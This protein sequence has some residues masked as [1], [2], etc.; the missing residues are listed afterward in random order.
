MSEQLSA[1][2]PDPYV[3]TPE[4]LDQMFR[5]MDDSVDLI[6]YKIANGPSEFQTQLQCNKEIDRNVRHL[7][8]MLGKPYIQDAGRPLGSYEQ[9]I[10]DG[11]AY[12]ASHGG[13]D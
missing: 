12:I 2:T 4:E 9:A 13:L 3:P 11:D 1:T 8:I 7:E 5:A 10:V 6:N